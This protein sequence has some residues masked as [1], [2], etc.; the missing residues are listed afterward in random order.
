V[1]TRKTVMVGTNQYPNANEFMLNEIE[2]SK[3]EEYEGINANR[4]SEG[5][6]NLRLSTE[7][8]VEK[9]GSRPVVFLLTIGNLAM[10]KARAGFATNFF[11]C[12]GY[13]IID[14]NGFETA[15]EGV[16]Q[17]MAKNADIV[18]V[19]SSDD[20]YEQIVPQVKEELNKQKP[21]AITVVAGYPK[22]LLDSFKAIGVENYIHVR[23]NVLEELKKY[24]NLLNI[25]KQN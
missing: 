23:S 16:A 3:E 9:G 24:N 19:C 20:E 11:G 8:F 21:N 12:A 18:V 22:E 13:E 4:R 17:A 14:N 25:E 7:N 10:R 6:E 2:V 5:F 15:Q 1:A